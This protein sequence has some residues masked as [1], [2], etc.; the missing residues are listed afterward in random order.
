MDWNKIVMTFLTGSL[1][2]LFVTHAQGASQLIGAVG[3]LAN[4]TGGIL[5]GRGA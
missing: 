5:S 1:V 2:V 4:T 3:G